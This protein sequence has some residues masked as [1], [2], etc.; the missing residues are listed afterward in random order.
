M[1]PCPVA[2]SGGQPTAPHTG[3][4]HAAVG[5][6]FPLMPFQDS[7]DQ[8]VDEWTT[9]ARQRIEELDAEFES[10]GWRRHA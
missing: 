5:A 10:A 2:V 4:E 1:L 8:A 6:E 7:T 9:L 3:A